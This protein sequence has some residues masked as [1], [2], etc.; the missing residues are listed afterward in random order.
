MSTTPVTVFV[1]PAEKSF[2]RLKRGRKTYILKRTVWE[3]RGL[4]PKMSG[5]MLQLVIRLDASGRYAGTSERSWNYSLCRGARGPLPSKSLLSV[6]AVFIA[7]K[8]CVSAGLACI[9]PWTGNLFLI[10][11][12]NEINHYTVK[13]SLLTQPVLLN[14]LKLLSWRL[15]ELIYLENSFWVSTG[16]FQSLVNLTML[17]LLISESLP[18]A[19]KN[20]VR[21][22]YRYAFFKLRFSMRVAGVI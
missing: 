13:R 4:I 21:S 12:N 11:R 20:S 19:M 14:S 7:E 15:A 17:S 18:V 1:V 8:N 3:F 22:R 16:K 2:K 9:R 10:V 5:K 6:T